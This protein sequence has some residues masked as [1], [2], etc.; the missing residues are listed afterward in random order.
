MHMHSSSIW[1]GAVP[2]VAGMAA[3]AVVLVLAVFIAGWID[4]WR[5]A[6]GTHGRAAGSSAAGRDHGVVI[7]RRGA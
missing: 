6:R 3:M 2:F 7:E 4:D 5:Q 1:D